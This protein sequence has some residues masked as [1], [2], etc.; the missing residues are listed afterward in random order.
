MGFDFDSPV[1]IGLRYG[2][3][4]MAVGISESCCRA[5]VVSLN[6]IK[7]APSGRKTVFFVM[8]MAW[9]ERVARV[10][11]CKSFGPESKALVVY[12]FQSRS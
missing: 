8:A 12:H 3:V 1:L 7:P 9:P 4:A 5:F 6:L 2:V 10:V 11:P